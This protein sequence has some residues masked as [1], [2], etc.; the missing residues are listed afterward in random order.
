MTIIM[1]MFIHGM[2]RPRQAP[3]RPRQAMVVVAHKC[4]L[5][6]LCGGEFKDG[7][8]M[9]SNILPLHFTYRRPTIPMMRGKTGLQRN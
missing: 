1:L 6:I 8:T 7:K 5:Q 9:L 3:G 4:S 2:I